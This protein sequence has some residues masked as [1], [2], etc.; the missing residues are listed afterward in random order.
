MIEMIGGGY[1]A[2]I[3]VQIKQQNEL[4]MENQNNSL[5]QDEERME[6]C[7]GRTQSLHM[8]IWLTPGTDHVH[9]IGSRF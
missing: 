3:S 5:H 6:R 2:K 8:R 7:T 4:K 9:I 1:V